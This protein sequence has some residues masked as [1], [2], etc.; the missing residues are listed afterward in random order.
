M[1]WIDISKELPPDKTTILVYSRFF[2]AEFHF[3]VYFTDNKFIRDGKEMKNFSHWMHLPKSP[4]AKPSKH[5]KI[6]GNFLTKKH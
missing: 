6:I 5:E 3:V 4:D 2:A 1:K